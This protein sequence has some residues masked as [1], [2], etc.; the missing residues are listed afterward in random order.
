MWTNSLLKQNAWKKVK[1]YYWPALGVTVL[2][3]IMGANGG[4]GGGGGGNT[5]AMTEGSDMSSEEAAALAI[6]I[7]VAMLVAY[8]VAGVLKIFLGNVA[9]CGENKYFV[10]AA[11]GDQ[12]FE[13]MFD[14]FRGGG[15]MPTVKTMFFKDLYV[16]LW[17]LLFII[18]GIIKSYEYALVPYLVAANPHIDKDRAL[19][20]SKKTMEGEKMNLFMLQLSFIGWYLLGLCACCIGVAF[21]NPYYEATMA[22]FWLCMRAK[23]ISYGFAGQDELSGGFGAYTSGITYGE[24]ASSDPYNTASG[25]NSYNA[26][27]PYDA[28][29]A[30]SPFSTPA[31]TEM[32]DIPDPNSFGSDTNDDT[33]GSNDDPY[34]N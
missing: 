11:E 24:T 17:T 22:E 8:A 4:G 31:S 32:P 1:N 34:N 33:D 30:P 20:I 27:N 3:S 13:H 15:Y 26:P 5:S 28:A 14:N 9:R 25:S 23:M 6:T 12:R 29:S 19:E 21:V 2:A 10:T 16:F 18:P 7:A